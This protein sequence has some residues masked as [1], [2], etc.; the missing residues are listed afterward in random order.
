MKGDWRDGECKEEM[1]K[2]AMVWTT[3]SIRQGNIHNKG[4]TEACAYEDGLDAWIRKEEL[5]KRKWKDGRL[6]GM[7][8]LTWIK[9]AMGGPLKSKVQVSSYQT[10]WGPSFAGQ[11]LAISSR[12]CSVS[13]AVTGACIRGCVSSSNNTSPKNLKNES[14]APLP[15]TAGIHALLLRDGPVPSLGDLVSQAPGSPLAD[16]H[17][18]HFVHIDGLCRGNSPYLSTNSMIP[19]P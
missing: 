1:R 14:T 5:Y 8:K 12:A 3:R 6:S 10:R 19:P 18:Y 7:G 4:L 9:D 2:T 16:L 17:I 13:T 11:T 15:A